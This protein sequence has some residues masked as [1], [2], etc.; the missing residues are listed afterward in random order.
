MSIPFACDLTAI[1]PGE[2]A[3]HHEATRQLVAAATIIRESGE[4]FAF[5]LAA[6]EYETV[7]RFVAKE[8]LCCPFLTFVVTARA[9]QPQ[10]ELRITGPAGAKE[11]IRAELHLPPG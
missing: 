10:V 8:R 6:D 11:F 1:P 7:T 9:N 4:G 3:A 2:R 5:E